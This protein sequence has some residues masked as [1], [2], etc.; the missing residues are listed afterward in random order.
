[1]KMTAELPEL[2]IK[3]QMK[4]TIIKEKDSGEFFLASVIQDS[5]LSSLQFASTGKEL[6][7]T[8]HHAAEVT[9]QAT[10]ETLDFNEFVV[11]ESMR[12]VMHTVVTLGGDPVQMS[13]AVSVGAVQGVRTVTG[14][15]SEKYLQAITLGISSAAEDLGF[16]LDSILSVTEYIVARAV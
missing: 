11:S 4:A 12:G 6:M 10:A 13:V 3:E 14:N 8:A 9:V 16:D 2:D 15:V 1:M 5:L 7:Q